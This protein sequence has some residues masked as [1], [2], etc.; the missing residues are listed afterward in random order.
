[1]VCGIIIGRQAGTGLSE[2][3]SA[4]HYANPRIRVTHRITP[5]A[6]PRQFELGRREL[7]PQASINVA[8][9]G[10][11]NPSADLSQLTYVC[12]TLDTLHRLGMPYSV[13]SLENAIAAC[14]VYGLGEHLQKLLAGEYKLRMQHKANQD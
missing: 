11:T 9:S 3:I 6:P 8:A 1:M 14:E 4:P 5:T 10:R 7:D 12:S 13:L 2:G